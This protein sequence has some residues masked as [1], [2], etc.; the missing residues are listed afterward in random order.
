MNPIT[1][2]F[3][4]PAFSL[5]VCFISSTSLADNLSFSQ[6]WS[7]LQENNDGLAAAYANQERSVHMVEAAE[8]SG[9]P[10]SP[11]YKDYKGRL[12]LVIIIFHQKFPA[13]LIK[14]WSEKVIRSIRNN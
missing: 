3:R 9:R 6:A 1:A 4:L 7:V 2:L 10:T 14:Y 13:V 11:G 5:L 8:H 12:R